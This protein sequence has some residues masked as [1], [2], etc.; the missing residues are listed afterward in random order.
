[1][2][3]VIT[4]FVSLV[5]KGFIVFGQ[6]SIDKAAIT[7]LAPNVAALSKYIDVPTIPMNGVAPINLPLF[8][9]GVGKLHVPV[10]LS[11]HSSGIKVTQQATWVG[12]GWSL[13][14]GGTIARTVNGVEDEKLTYGWFNQ[15]ISADS[16]DRI[17]DYLTLDNWSNDRPDMK[18]DIFNYSLPSQAGKFVYSRDDKKFRAIPYAPVVINRDASVN[19]YSIVDDDGTKYYFDMKNS[20][21]N[22][23]HTIR[24]YVQSW[25]LT[26]MVSA[27]GIDSIDFSYTS[28]GE[29]ST[30]A[31]SSVRYRKGESDDDLMDFVRENASTTVSTNR[32]GN[33]ILKEIIYRDGKVV[34]YANTSRKDG[35]ELASNPRHALDSIVVFN[36]KNGGYQRLK[37][38]VFTYDYFATQF[39]S[40]PATSRLK[41]TSYSTI[42]INGIDS[43]QTYYF[44]YNNIPLPDPT[45]YNMDYW[46]YYNGRNNGSLLP[47]ILPDQDALKKFGSIGLANREPDD[48]FLQAGILTSITYPTG[49]RTVF[50]YE[51]NKV[52]FSQAE[53]K[54]GGLFSFKLA[55]TGR[56]STVTR[57]ENF[58]APQ[59]LTGTTN[60]GTVRITLSP[61]SPNAVIEA[62]TVVFRDL[63][64]GTDIQTWIS[65]QFSSEYAKSHI[66]EYP[67]NFDTTHT[68]QVYVAINDYATT[69]VTIDVI[70]QIRT[71]SE[72]IVSGGG[73]RNKSINYYDAND[74]LKRR[75][76]YS[77][78][79]N[80]EGYGVTLRPIDIFYKNYYTKGLRRATPTGGGTSCV[81]RNGAQIIYLGQAS[82][83]SVSF[84]GG[85]VIYPAVV[86]YDWDSNGKP[87]G[88]TLFSYIIPADYQ[89][90]PNPVAVGGKDF[91][92]NSL[93]DDLLESKKLFKYNEAGNTYAL[94]S[95]EENEYSLFNWRE[96][97]CASVYNTVDWFDEWRCVVGDPPLTD[98]WNNSYKIKLG[99]FLPS[100]VT[101]TQYT[102]DGQMI[103]SVTNY[104]YN[105]ALLPDSIYTIDSKGVAT[106]I[107]SHYPGDHTVSDPN[108][109]VLNQ[110]VT[111]NILK[112]PYWKGDYRNNVL[113]R[114]LV[115]T[116]KSGW[117][118]IA[119]Q[120]FPSSTL[121]K[122]RIN[123]TDVSADDMSYNAY[124][125]YGNILEQQKSNDVKEVY[126]W[127]Y[128]GRYPVAKIMGSDYATAK[129]KITQSVLDNAT[130]ITTDDAMRAELDRLRTGLPGALIW[131]YTY[132]PLFGLT[133]ETDP[134]GR[135]KYYEYDGF[136]RLKCVKGQD[137][138]IIKMYEYK[139]QLPVN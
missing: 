94:V 72:G 85:D 27:D 41:L 52:H 32:I 10:S 123:G 35:L 39:N 45:S 87:N 78:G 40:S 118:G 4:I 53:Y 51:P 128:N 64:A 25:N 17:K 127:G 49:G 63:T 122:T 34:F 68:Y 13:M 19:T 23:D 36:K 38:I 98:F 129:T 9:I 101:N 113:Q 77:Y 111:A 99:K 137:G 120:I 125:I 83:P 88:K 37:K 54:E 21:F 84:S 135:T 31:V 136:G 81:V 62:Q 92:G 86:Q 33:P 117:N 11:Y 12:L 65:G 6:V 133:S 106:S 66:I 97:Y 76:T 132:A 1:M 7:P 73:V 5:L 102:D 59:V 139:Y 2:K 91:V 8:D 14:P 112:Q 124:D 61:F 29:V 28:E 138:K 95:A 74:T 108:V 42:D 22:D 121:L 90:V 116:F 104:H 20:F 44:S 134:A 58:K 80:E 43:A 24:S 50:E 71:V 16:A 114:F 57:Q 115:T 105:N 70:V 3:R 47:N 107:T 30:S 100:K 15:N 89:S 82:Y 96:I 48:N 69:T 46:G 67:Y 26:K 55:G 110:M 56:N 109:T 75:T 126:L 93:R 18:A 103:Q 60:A 119:S 79:K 130:G 131:T